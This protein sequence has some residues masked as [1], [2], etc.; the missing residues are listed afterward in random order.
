MGTAP[1]VLKSKLSPPPP[2][3]QGLVPRPRLWARLDEG[4]RHQLTLV[5]A[6]AG[7]GKTSL[8]SRWVH[9]RRSFPVAWYT[10]EE[11]DADLHNFLTYLNAALAPCLPDISSR[12][13][14]VLTAPRVDLDIA[15]FLLIDGLAGLETP[16][17]LVLDDVQR[18]GVN[19]EVLR[20]LDRILRH[21]SPHFHLILSARREPP[22]AT[23]PK[24]RAQGEVT[25]LNE[26]DTRFTPSEAMLLLTD[27]FGIE[28]NPEAAA[29]MVERTEGWPIALHLVYQAWARHGPEEVERLMEQFGGT[30]RQV[31]DYLARVVLEGQPKEVCT[32]LYRTSILE[33]LEPDVCNALTGRDDAI[34]TLGY[35]ERSGLFTFPAD[36][37]RTAYRYHALFR[38]FLLRRLRETEGSN[39]VRG[40]H[41]VVAGWFLEHG[42][43]EAAIEHLLS[44]GEYQAAGD[45]IGVIW[46]KLLYQSRVHILER[47]LK[48]FPRKLLEQQPRLLLAQAKLADIRGDLRKAEALCKK[49]E[50][51]L[52]GEEDGDF[53]HALYHEQARLAAASVGDFP[54]A[55]ALERKA[56][57]HASTDD[58]RIVSLSRAAYYTY[59]SRGPSPEIFDLLQRA[60]DLAQHIDD[61]LV[62]ADLFLM[63]AGIKGRQGHLLDST[64]DRMTAMSLMESAG[65]R[66]GQSPS[67][68]DTAYQYYLLG[69]L[70]EASSQLQKAIALTQ[71]FGRR[72][73]YAYALNIRGLLYREQGRLE[74]ARR[75]H[76]EAL[77]IQKQ[78][79]EEY[80]TAVTLNWLGTLNRFEGR[81]EEALRLGTES[82]NLRE[83]LG[84][85]YETGLSL[86]D[87]GAIHL[88][89][90][91]EEAA[92]EMWRRAL[93]IF[94]RRQ[95]R[96]E[97]T[98]LHFYL[99]V[100]AQ[101]RGDEAALAEHLGKAMTLARTYEHGD[102]PRCLQIFLTE[103]EWTAPLLTH[104]I[105]R[106]LA[107]AC[108]ECLLPRLGKPALKAL[109]PLLDDA[110]P[111]A[112]AR[113]ARLLGR[114]RDVE[115]LKPL[116]RHRRDA[117]E[118]VRNTIASAIASLLKVPP[119]PLRVQTLG[120]FRLWRGEQEISAWPRRSAR[121]VLLLLLQHHP[122][123]VASEALTEALWPDS[124][125][126][127]AAQSLRRAISDLR[128]TL[129]PELPS[130]LPSRYVTIS[131]G[132]YLMNLPEGSRVDD[133][134]FEEDLHR[135]MKAP[136]GTAD[137]R[138][139][140]IERLETAL[141]LYRGDYLPDVP[142][143]DWV[144]RRREYLRELF[145]RGN[146]ILASLYVD[147]GRNEEAIT[148]ADKILSMD[149]WDE[150]AVMVKMKALAAE[151]RVSAALRAYETLRERLQNDLRLSPDEK[152]TAFYHRLRGD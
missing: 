35:L 36:S 102:P 119:E 85:E 52:R 13:R 57:A 17:A 77:A 51:L 65:Y 19:R 23:I 101:R 71:E 113:A 38:E 42:R 127:R 6:P 16:C 45:L 105:R 61:P 47:W 115:A 41:R 88:E 53:L 54:T 90:G 86:I 48:R 81:L 109:V 91:E 40:L 112:R 82:L 96:Y 37:R 34:A 132:T 133:R 68:G 76:E 74:D 50:H 125:P 139:A 60:M 144:L 152:L 73:H 33:H 97:Q 93:D 147:E 10:L 104:A 62:L 26:T 84:N 43:D 120:G 32:F 99:A 106:G 69:D 56:L 111:E 30:M 150:S 135:A 46:T 1:L 12:I 151:G 3:R 149:P 7:Y 148:V 2:P 121:N 126:D 98:Q 24:L 59:M 118:N 146:R 64:E 18:V 140:A 145:L 138:R 31:Y 55:N 108:A 79:G 123:P 124:T 8:L 142:F 128:Q 130:Y 95:A 63:R 49:A 100:L 72:S 29:R 87:V 39:A 20:L 117:D 114:L 22:L 66:H 14:E 107:T 11:E 80:E 4:L 15:S 143:D 137:E 70:E 25:E 141:R 67:L 28:A 131:H 27:I 134:D 9:R 78:L 116:Y 129:E 21:A 89:R 75:S 136:H 110:S 92:E 58:K 94:E 44:A 103:A 122:G 83:K 5:L